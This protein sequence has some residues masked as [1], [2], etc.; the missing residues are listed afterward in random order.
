MCGLP[1][2][3]RC[4][5]QARVRIDL[6]CLYE[7]PTCEQATDWKGENGMP[8]ESSDCWITQGPT[9]WVACFLHINWIWLKK[10]ERSMFETANQKWHQQDSAWCCAAAT[11]ARYSAT[12]HFSTFIS[13]DS[14]QCQSAF[15][16]LHWLLWAILTC[17]M[18][19]NALVS[20]SKLKM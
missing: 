17:S 14:Q 4:H 19:N 5:T 7:K 20:N 12:G 1:C 10:T 11:T 16:V 2:V 6:I 3:S 13:W 8:Q 9:G 18:Q 15:T